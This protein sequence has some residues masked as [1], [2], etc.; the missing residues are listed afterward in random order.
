M[1]KVILMDLQKAKKAAGEQN[2]NAGYAK[3][4]DGFMNIPDSIDG[5]LPFM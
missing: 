2:Q 4:D 3:S 5:E 1:N